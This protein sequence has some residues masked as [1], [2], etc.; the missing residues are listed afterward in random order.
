M[1]WRAFLL[2]RKK[3]TL[4]KGSLA[5]WM[6]VSLYFLLDLLFAEDIYI[7][8]D[9]TIGERD[10]EAPLGH[11]LFCR[12]FSTKQRMFTAQLK[13]GSIQLAVS[14]LFSTLQQCHHL[15]EPSENTNSSSKI[16]LPLQTQM[17]ALSLTIG[18]HL[19]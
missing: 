11:P 8:T 3:K 4:D 19:H 13:S 1:N 14:P 10:P 12:H 5:L 17:E 18:D 15:W 9:L 6:G 2:P 7:Y 16:D